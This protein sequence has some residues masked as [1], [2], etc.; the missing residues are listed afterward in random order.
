MRD[1]GDPISGQLIGQKALILNE[2]LNGSPDFKVSINTYNAS[3][4]Y[5]L[6]YQMITL[7]F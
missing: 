1:R 5:T 6:V 4:K 2:K 7:K 3:E